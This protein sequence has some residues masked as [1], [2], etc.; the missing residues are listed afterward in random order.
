MNFKNYGNDGA[1]ENLKKLNTIFVPGFIS[2]SLG[3][4]AAVMLFVHQLNLYNIS[5]IF[6]FPV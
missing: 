1:F 2:G 3:G 4:I 6:R 5:D